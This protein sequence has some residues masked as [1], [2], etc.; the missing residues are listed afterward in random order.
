M[1][2]ERRHELQQNALA[3]G[4]AHMPSNLQRYGGRILAGL[5]LVLLIIILVRTRITSSREGQ[6]AAFENLALAR[7]FIDELRHVDA[8][9]APPEQIATHRRQLIED[10]T[11]AIAAV[12][13]LTDAPDQIAQALVAR[14]DLN[15]LAA[16]LTPLPSATTQPA[17]PSGPSPEERLDIARKAYREIVQNH[18]THTYSLA[19]ARLGLAAIAEN[20]GEWDE[21]KAQYEAILNDDKIIQPFKTQ[22]DLRLRQIPRLRHPVYIA[23]APTTEASA[24]ETPIAPVNDSEA[25][26]AT[27]QPPAA[28]PATQPGEA[29]ST[30]PAS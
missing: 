22:A 4:L 26:E 21:A 12:R 7:T 6:R 29:P 8:S 15:W 30:Q 23:P 20:L 14:G 25:I 11:T 27:E 28:P 5:I 10:A 16:N 18:A 9:F 3:A 19:S 1:K 2:S 17:L 13:D 24:P